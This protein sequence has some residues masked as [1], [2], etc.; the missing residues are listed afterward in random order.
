[1]QFFYLL[2]I[3]NENKYNINYICEDE[4][5]IFIKNKIKQH[6]LSILQSLYTKYK[7]EMT[8]KCYALLE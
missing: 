2:N 1:M 3:N 6:I 4:E 8:T 7:E 5:N